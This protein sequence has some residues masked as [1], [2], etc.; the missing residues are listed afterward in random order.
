MRGA[1]LR[2]IAISVSLLVFFAAPTQAESGFLVRS[3]LIGGETYR[4]LV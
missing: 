1:S 2:F 4:Y 3:L